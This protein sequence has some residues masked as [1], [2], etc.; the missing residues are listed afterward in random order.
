MKFIT[1]RKFSFLA[2]AM[3]VILF[4]SSH[5]PY[6]KQDVKPF[7]K[8]MVS[9]QEEDLPPIAFTYDGALVTPSAPYEYVEFFLRKGAHVVSFGLLAFLC[10]MALKEQNKKAPIFLGSILAFLYALFDEFHQSLVEGRTGHLIDVFVPDLLGILLIL[11]LFLIFSQ[12]KKHGQKP[13]Q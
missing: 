2:I 11:M 5:T 10:I 8:G 6:Q 3:M 13:R 12:K 4:I 9:I 7:F 1:K